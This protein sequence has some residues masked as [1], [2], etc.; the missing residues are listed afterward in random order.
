MSD[1]MR[2]SHNLKISPAT[3]SNIVMDA[4]RSHVLDDFETAAIHELKNSSVVH[5]DERGGNLV[6]K[7]V[8]VRVALNELVTS[9]HLHPKRGRESMIYGGILP[10]F[11]GIDVT[12]CLPSYDIFE[13]VHSI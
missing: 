3:L 8:F 1:V 4:C 13:N 5:F 12:D 2:D 6:R 7:L 10:F 11:K 9:L